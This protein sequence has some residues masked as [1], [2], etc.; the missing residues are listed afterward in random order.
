MPNRPRE[1]SLDAPGGASTALETELPGSLPTQ[2]L[3]KELEANDIENAGAQLAA[4]ME[5]LGYHPVILFGSAASGKTSL[6]ASLL[7]TVRTEPTLLVT[8]VLGDPLLSLKS[9][10]GRY[11]QSRSEAFYFKTV[12]DFIDGRAP[13][14][15]NIQLPFFVPVVFRPKNHSELRFAFMESNGEWYRPDRSSDA[16]FPVLRSEIENFI[17]HYQKGITFVH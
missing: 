10:Y 9:K 11:L 17:R 6:L 15:T 3:D 12:Q 1:F 5:E 16:F 14:K 4:Q 7:A 2:K 8:T 13:A